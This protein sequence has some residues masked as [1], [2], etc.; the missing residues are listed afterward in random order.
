MILP[1]HRSRTT[2]RHDGDRLHAKASGH[3]V[4][5][6]GRTRLGML[7]AVRGPDRRAGVP[8]RPFAWMVTARVGTRPARA[9]SPGALSP[10]PFG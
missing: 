6:D 10:M 4:H 2:I 8:L 9:L 1:N 5:D 3:P 7:T